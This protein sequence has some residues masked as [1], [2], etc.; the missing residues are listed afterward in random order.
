MPR[1]LEL[2]PHL[3]ADDLGHRYRHSRDPVERTHWHMVWLIAQGHHCPAVATMLGYGED[4]VRTIMHRY[5]DAG[6]SGITDRRHA[7]LGQPPLLSPALREELG[8]ALDG[9]PPDGGLWTSPK[10]AAWMAARLGRPVSRQRAWEAMR[11]LGFTLQQPRTRATAADPDAQ[12]AF[13][14]GGS[15]RRWIRSDPPTPAPR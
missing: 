12:E 5:N 14:K 3:S 9:D 2:A 6:P 1:C 10:V 8:E 13:K 7:N 11:S 4:W 15:P